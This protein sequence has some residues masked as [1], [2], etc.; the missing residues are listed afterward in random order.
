MIKKFNILLVILV[1]QLVSACSDDLDNRGYVTKFSDFTKI[2]TGVSTKDE[3]ES[4]LGSPTTKSLYG[5]EEW[6]YLG[7]EVTK[8][9]FFEPEVKNYEAYI[10]TFNSD[11]VVEKI[12]K[13]DEN[14]LKEI[15]I[16]DDTTATG[17]SKVTV[18]QQLLGN[19]G[20]F[21]ATGSGPR[22]AGVLGGGR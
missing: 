19:L 14:S 11:D 16:S 12:A 10:I 13:R 17:G 18:I 2:E 9:T 7:S 15:E 3:V 6:I 22:S 8:E 20:K 1:F 4:L 5:K 21:D